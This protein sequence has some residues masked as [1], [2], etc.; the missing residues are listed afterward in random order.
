MLN[1]VAQDQIQR[2][3]YELMFTFICIYDKC[4][5]NYECMCMHGLESM[6]L[7]PSSVH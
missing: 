1:S 7:F 2:H 4:R 6:H 5:N 3:Q